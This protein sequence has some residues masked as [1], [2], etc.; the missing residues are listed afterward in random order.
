MQINS[1][2]DKL[3]AYQSTNQFSKTA[4]QTCKRFLSDSYLAPMLKQ[5]NVLSLTF[6]CITP[7]QTN[8]NYFLNH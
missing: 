1:R 3:I 6:M 7:G 2:T 5:H 4:V 8:S